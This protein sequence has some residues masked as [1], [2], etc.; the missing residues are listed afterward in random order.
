MQPSFGW[1]AAALAALRPLAGPAD[2][3]WPLRIPNPARNAVDETRSPAIILIAENQNYCYS[4][5]RIEKARRARSEPQKPPSEWARKRAAGKARRARLVERR[6]TDF[7]LL[8]SSFVAELDGTHGSQS[9]RPVQL[10][11]PPRIAPPVAGAA[12]PDARAAHGRSPRE[13]KG[14]RNRLTSLACVTMCAAPS[15]R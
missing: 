4:G 6:E 3:G 10:A 8:M 2:V 15:A 7:D 9:M 11:R 14:G 5:F 1:G 12:R 13:R